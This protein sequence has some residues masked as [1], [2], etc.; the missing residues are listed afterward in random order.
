MIGPQGLSPLAAVAG[1]TV[2]CIDDNMT[3]VDALER[4]LAMEP[5]F[6]GLTR[7]ENFAESVQRVLEHRPS[8]VILDVNL[9]GVDAFEILAQ[10]VTQAPESRVI[11]FTGHATSEVAKAAF[12]AGAWGF[13]SKGARAEQVIDAVRRVLAGE[14]VIALDD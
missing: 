4:R 12:A 6:L 3:L 11:I 8:I 10:V 13:A 14:A 9:P 5:G 7:V 1:F 2:L